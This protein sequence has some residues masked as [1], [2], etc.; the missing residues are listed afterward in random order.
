MLI[1]EEDYERVND[2]RVNVKEMQKKIESDMQ[3]KEQKLQAMREQKAIKET[4]GCTFAPQLMTKKKK[5]EQPKRDL[6]KFLDD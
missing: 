2:N 6:N 3:R 4:E 5:V 1:P